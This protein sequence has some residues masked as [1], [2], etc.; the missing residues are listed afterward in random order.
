[1]KEGIM[2]TTTNTGT[3]PIF[4][5]YTAAYL[6]MK[7]LSPA[8]VKRGTRVVFDFPGEDRTL[9]LVNDFNANPRIY[10]IDYVSALRTMRARMLAHR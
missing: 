5:I 1:M 6:Y 7:G 4:D 2:K 3:V 10:L 8:F 9:D